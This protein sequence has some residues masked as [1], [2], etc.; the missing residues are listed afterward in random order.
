MKQNF[1]FGYGSL[2]CRHSRATTVAS[3][4]AVTTTPVIVSGLQVMWSCRAPYGMTALGVVIQQQQEP[5]STQAAAAAIGV[6]VPVT[7]TELVAF[8]EREGDE[9][10]RTMVPLHDVATVPFLPIEK[11]YAHPHHGH[12]LKA[13]DKQQDADIRIWVYVQ[14][15][16]LP[17]APS[18]PIVQT[19]VDTILR[20]CL[21]ISEDFAS[22]F[23][24]TVQGWHSDDNDEQRNPD[25]A[26][27]HYVNDR[28]APIYIRGDPAWSLQHAETIDRLIRT[29]R[30][31]HYQHRKELPPAASFS[32]SDTSCISSTTG[33][34]SE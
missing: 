24:E 4:S 19:Y 32:S 25:A 31:V 23:L 13:K 22:T 9:Y 28:Y 6:L 20:G 30:P 27:I 3:G 17:A 29:H 5:K 10:E 8:D 18:H 14:K 1:V 15:E 7:E 34:K 21:E 16:P 33:N 26:T 11:H 12:F 2:I